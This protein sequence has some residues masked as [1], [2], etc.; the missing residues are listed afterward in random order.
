MG[1]YLRVGAYQLF[2]PTGW[3]LIRNFIL[4][5]LAVVRT[6]ICGIQQIKIFTYS[7]GQN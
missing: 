2:L 4:F 3:A 5:S 1:A 7:L 6:S